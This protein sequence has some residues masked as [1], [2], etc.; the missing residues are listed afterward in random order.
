MNV[1][2]PL[3]FLGRNL[4]KYNGERLGGNEVMRVDPSW[5]G[6]TFKLEDG[7]HPNTIMLDLWFQTSG[8]QNCETYFPVVNRTPSLLTLCCGSLNWKHS[9]WACISFVGTYTK[10]FDSRIWKRYLYNRIHRS[11]NN[12]SQAVVTTQLPNGRWLHELW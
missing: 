3:K 9:I 11:I 4:P 8:P 1:G 2:V 5:V 6:Y 10:K 12:N 7:P